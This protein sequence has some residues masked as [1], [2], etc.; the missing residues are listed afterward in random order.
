MLC[1]SSVLDAHLF[2][3][4]DSTMISATESD[5][6]REIVANMPPIAICSIAR[7]C[8]TFARVVTV[9]MWL[10]SSPECDCADQ[11]DCCEDDGRKFRD[12][13]YEAAAT[14]DADG[15]KTVNTVVI[16]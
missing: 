5:A 15:V 7:M 11:S 3:H 10:S 8:C 14:A 9:N 16:C 4:F 13:C 12:W 2:H 6:I 1:I